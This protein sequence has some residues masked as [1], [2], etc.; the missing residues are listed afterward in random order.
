MTPLQELFKEAIEK[1]DL[2]ITYELDG[3]HITKLSPVEIH[4]AAIACE[5]IADE[6]ACDFGEWVDN[7]EW[8]YHPLYN[9]WVGYD[10]TK[11]KT[12]SELLQQFK[13]ERK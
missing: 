9:L 12:T 11:R 8:T 7:G 2:T 4:A 6:F 5:K 3:I 10:P 13:E 1:Q